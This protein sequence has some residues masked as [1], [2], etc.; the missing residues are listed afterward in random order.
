MY[1]NLNNCLFPW[2]VHPLAT[3]VSFGGQPL[4]WPYWQL[5]DYFIQYDD[6]DGNVELNSDVDDGGGGKI[7]QHWLSAKGMI[8]KPR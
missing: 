8:L 2:F 5:D 6:D 1:P 7:G 3:N 4:L